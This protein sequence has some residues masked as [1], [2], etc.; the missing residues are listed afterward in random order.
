MDIDN[1]A[2]AIME[3]IEFDK[4]V[5]KSS[6]VEV[7][8]RAM[9]APWATSPSQPN[10][11]SDGTVSWADPDWDIKVGANGVVRIVRRA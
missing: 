5:H 6:L 8:Q 2:E 9:N 4:A 7:I 10:M 11:L 3:R 1:L